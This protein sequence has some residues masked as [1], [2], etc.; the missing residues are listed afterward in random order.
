ML[1]IFKRTGATVTVGLIAVQNGPDPTMNLLIGTASVIVA[2]KYLNPFGG[3]LFAGS[4]YLFL[5]GALSQISSLYLGVAPEGTQL[6][7]VMLGGFGFAIYLQYYIIGKIVGIH[8]LISLIWKLINTVVTIAFCFKVALLVPLSFAAAYVSVGIPLVDQFSYVLF[9][10]GTLG[11]FYIAY[12]W[13]WLLAI[14]SDIKELSDI[15]THQSNIISSYEYVHLIITTLGIIHLG[16]TLQIFLG[17]QFSV[18]SSHELASAVSPLIIGFSLILGL[19]YSLISIIANGP[20]S[21][22]ITS[23]LFSIPFI[24]LFGVSVFLDGQSNF[25]SNYEGYTIFLSATLL[26]LGGFYVVR[27]LDSEDSAEGTQK[28]GN[29][30]MN[31]EEEL[32]QLRKEVE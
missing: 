8:P 18:A 2:T 27:R 24:I 17:Q 20:D 16:Y 1:R 30:K 22:V 3:Y 19:G 23:H 13:K 31:I 25:S 5:L 6:W 28:S 10:A 15:D 7:L 11:V 21:R 14:K 4:L 29:D 32:E 9:A 12:N 26:S